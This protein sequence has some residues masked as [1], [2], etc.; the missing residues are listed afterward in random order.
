MAG[1]PRRASL[2]P[3]WLDVRAVGEVD[4][5]IKSEMPEAD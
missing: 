4:S 3:R 5:V 2:I 1:L